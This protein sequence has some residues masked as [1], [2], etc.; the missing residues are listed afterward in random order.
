MVCVQAYGDAEAYAKDQAGHWVVVHGYDDESIHIQD[1]TAGP[2]KIA[3]ETFDA[4]WHDREE[5][6]TRY[7]H[8]GIAFQRVDVEDYAESSPLQAPDS[9]DVALAGKDGQRVEKLLTTSQQQGVKV[10]ARI[11]REAVTRLAGRGIKAMASDQLFTAEEQQQLADSLAATNATAN[12]LGRSR[13]RE[14]Q[15]KVYE[16]Y[17]PARLSELPAVVRLFDDT[18]PDAPPIKPLPPE[19]ALEYFQNLSPS[20]DLEPERFGSLMKRE[21]FTLAVRTD[22][23]ILDKV[24]AAIKNRLATGETAT[25]LPTHAEIESILDAVGV[26]PANPQYSEMVYRTNMMDSYTVGA[27][28][29]MRDPDVASTFPVW[30]YLGIRDGRQGEDHEPHFDQYFPNEASFQE[31]RGDRVFNCR[32]NPQPINKFLWARLKRGGARIA[33]G[34]TDPT[35]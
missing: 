22:T 3:N 4:Q 19:K 11:A 34:Y 9:G 7:D 15:R 16:K 25:L 13:I 23:V 1:P 35:A 33:D 21:A 14:Q 32:C 30:R 10:L 17:Q 24:K 18:A 6:G 12:L 31:V 8:Y 26:T 5:D 2:L 28:E 27:M 20:L 29:E